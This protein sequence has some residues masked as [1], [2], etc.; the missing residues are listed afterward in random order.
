MTEPL[1]TKTTPLFSP[2]IVA[3]NRSEE[4]WRIRA[5]F[6][7]NLIYFQGH[8][9]EFKLLPG[10]ALLKITCDLLPDEL[11]SK[12]VRTIRK[13][14]FMRV[15]RPKDE[16]ELQLHIAEDHNYVDFHWRT[17]EASYACGRFEY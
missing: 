1:Q 3:S 11:S 15:I 13:L 7:E 2:E 12:P 5:R 17:I 6:P 4:T 9:A 14:K 10:V 8:F 16:L